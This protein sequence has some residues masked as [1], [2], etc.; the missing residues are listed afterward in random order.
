LEDVRVVIDRSVSQPRTGGL[1]NPI[2]LLSGLATAVSGAEFAHWSEI[3]I[4]TAMDAYSTMEFKGPFDPAR[5]EMRDTFR[6]FSFFPVTVTVG[7]ET[8]FTGTQVG[9]S[10]E[11]TANESVVHLS[12]YSLPGVLEDNTAPASALPLEF[13]KLKL[14]QILEQVGKMF[15]LSLSF[16]GDDG[17]PFERQR[18]EPAQKV[19]QFLEELVRLRG[20]VLTSTPRGEILCWKGTPT[21]SPVF[22]FEEG[23]QPFTGSEAMFSPQDYHSEITA[24]TG[25]RRG[26]PG[27]KFTEP[28]P[29]LRTSLRPL[30]ISI[31][32]NEKAD[33][34]EAA[35]SAMGRMFAN[36]A[37]WS[38]KEIPT[39]RDPK[40]KLWTPG[41]TVTVTAPSAMIYQ[42]T[43][44]ML[45]AVNFFQD[46]NVEFASL[47]LVF[48]EAFSGEPPTS[49]PWDE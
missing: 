6:P 27:A 41:T 25:A 40:G 8:L 34:P 37:S 11:R 31:E 19:Q 4:R 5:K 43:R 12:A 30:N 44:L 1:S 29:W 26:R 42:R 13:N 18:L 17:G 10:P 16:V 7:G 35:R 33:G 36:M 22:N 24:F 23:V 9:V 15:G 38:I 47:E 20:R 3:R 46:R 2:T 49:M 45:R 39:W 14:R 48:P 32:K 21:G 28:N